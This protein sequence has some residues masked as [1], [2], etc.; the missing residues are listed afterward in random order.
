VY[1]ANW[2]GGAV[3]K[4]P[5]GGGNPVAVASGQAAPTGIAVDG[6]NIYW[7]NFDDNTVMKC[8]VTGCTQPV[9]VASGQSNPAGIAVDA[10]S[11]YWTNSGTLSFP[12][13]GGEMGTGALMKALL[14]GGAPTPLASAE[15]DPWAL[16][17]DDA[18]V[19][20]GAGDLLTCPLTG[21]GGVPTV[22]VPGA[23]ANGLATDGVTVYWTGGGI[24]GY[25]RKA[26]VDGGGQ[27]VIASSLN[28]PNGIAIGATA[29]YWT[30]QGSGR[31]VSAP[32]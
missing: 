14:D 2:G 28:E 15:V 27:T 30:E 8:P 29:V 23:G 1:W 11:V 17:I 25:V 3:M 4:V 10:T 24:Y 31:I 16:A 12:P 6:T 7:T 22:L 19:Y 18:N 5:I 26:G 32:K 9:L 21:C 13:G 20:W